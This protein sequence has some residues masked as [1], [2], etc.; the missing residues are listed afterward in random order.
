VGKVL[1]I[2]V[3]DADDARAEARHIL[4]DFEARYGVP[5]ERLMEPFLRADGH[6]NE[7][8][9]FRAWAKAWARWQ[10]LTGG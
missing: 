3:R 10:I 9:E 6:V 8:K 2:G 4:D 7:T 5:S 1:K